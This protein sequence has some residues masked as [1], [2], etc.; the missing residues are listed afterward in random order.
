MPEVC[1]SAILR[2]DLYKS[3]TKMITIAQIKQSCHSLIVVFICQKSDTVVVFITA[4][5]HKHIDISCG[6]ISMTPKPKAID[7]S[8]VSLE[9]CGL[10]RVCRAHD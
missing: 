2:S 10:V 3:R 9:L 8:L 5:H 4:K 7:T 6:C 1:V